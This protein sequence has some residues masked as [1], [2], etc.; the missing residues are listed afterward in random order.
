MQ[1]PK[2]NT[3]CKLKVTDFERSLSV[4]ECREILR[5]GHFSDIIEEL[6]PCILV[7]FLFLAKEPGRI[8]VLGLQQ[9]VSVQLICDEAMK[10]V[11]GQLPD[12][13]RLMV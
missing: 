8:S 2:A 11:E 7:E 13:L 9:A 4:D 10:L 5:L 3:L 1:C 6:D 12:M